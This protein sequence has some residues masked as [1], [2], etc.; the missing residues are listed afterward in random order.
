MTH[1]I[2]LIDTYTDMT[3]DENFLGDFLQDI[4]RRFGYPD[5]KKWGVTAR[6]FK[7]VD[8]IIPR[9]KKKKFLEYIK[10]FEPEWLTQDRYGQRMP[11]NQSLAFKYAMKFN[12]IKVDM[13]EV[14]HMKIDKMEMIT[15]TGIR[16]K[17]G[18][19]VLVLGVLDDY[20]HPKGTG[21]ELL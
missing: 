7:F 17:Q 14:K 2:C 3:K 1:I 13:S 8:F 10:N 11:F 16:W 4:W 12:P 20:Q 9:E 18:V 6:E 15:K 5:A 19:Q 21:R